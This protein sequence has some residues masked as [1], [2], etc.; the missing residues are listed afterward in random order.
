MLSHGVNV[1]GLF[2]I[3]DI[4]QRRTDTRD[5]NSLG[6]IRLD[7]PVF[8]TFF[9]IILLASIALP[10]TNGFV[11]EFLL[12]NGIYQC[13]TAAAVFAGLTIIFGA[14]YM[15]NAYRKIML[16]DKSIHS[17][18]FNEL[19]SLEKG[20]MIPLVILIFWMGIYPEFFLGISE[21]SVKA[22]REII[23]SSRGLMSNPI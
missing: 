16:G 10:L 14:V 6:G 8:A 17:S 11:G 21:P 5:M 2:F 15:L 9:I 19:S 23:Y 20:V 7:A 4:I 22:L 18:V 13:S 12:I 3:A 1:V